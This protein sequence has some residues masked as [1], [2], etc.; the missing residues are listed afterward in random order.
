MIWLRSQI[1]DPMDYGGLDTPALL[2][3]L[4]LLSED[5]IV[6]AVYNPDL[7]H[8]KKGYKNKE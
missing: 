7:K 8:P 5:D 6:I 3:S 4:A 1:P 2:W